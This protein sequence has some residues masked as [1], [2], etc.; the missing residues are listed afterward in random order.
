MSIIN[1]KKKEKF[2]DKVRRPH[3]RIV[4]I[5]TPSKIIFYFEGSKRGQGGLNWVGCYLGQIRY[6]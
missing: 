2:A 4:L 1:F 3:Y 5:K 6:E